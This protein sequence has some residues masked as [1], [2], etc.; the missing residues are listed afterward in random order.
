MTP[1]ITIFKLNTLLFTFVGLA[2]GIPGM[3]PYPATS[4]R[5]RISSEY[6]TYVAIGLTLDDL[7]IILGWFF[8]VDRTSSQT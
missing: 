1:L 6:T 8:E 3:T 7:K 4:S 5:R 2:A